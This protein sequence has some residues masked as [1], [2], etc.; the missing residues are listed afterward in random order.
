MGQQ[1]GLVHSVP[2]YS[3]SILIPLFLFSM[4]LGSPGATCESPASSGVMSRADRHHKA[5]ALMFAFDLFDEYLTVY[6]LRLS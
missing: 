5:P 4:A 1:R 2:S 6:S 3:P